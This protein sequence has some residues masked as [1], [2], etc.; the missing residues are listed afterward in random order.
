MNGLPTWGHMR[1][2]VR[3]AARRAVPEAVL[4]RARDLR[5][6]HRR[7]GVTPSETATALA[8]RLVLTDDGFTQDPDPYLE[9][10]RDAAAVHHLRRQECWLVVGYDAARSALM[11][12]QDFSSHP[13][14]GVES[15]LLGAD[16]ERHRATRRVL[17]PWFSTDVMSSARVYAE[18]AAT[19]LLSPL[20]GGRQFDVVREL[21]APLPT[22]VAG[23]LLGFDDALLS[24]LNAEPGWSGNLPLDP[25]AGARPVIE[26]SV[27]AVPSY[28]KLVAENDFRHDEAVDLIML[29]LVAGTVTTRGVLGSL[30]LRLADRA[31]RHEIT[32]RPEL[33]PGF[34]EEVLRLEPPVAVITRKTSRDVI[35]AGVEIPADSH[36]LV[37]TRA[38][39]RDPACFPDPGRLVLERPNK[40]DHL[41]FAAGPHHCLGARLARMELAVGVTVLLRLM[42]DFELVQPQHTLRY[43]G[44]DIR[45]VEQL[46]IRSARAH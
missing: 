18:E 4:G 9:R 7:P 23:W 29:L 36:V 15:T 30:V 32:S 10:L 34:I 40:R 3:A 31:V 46:V 39:N 6:P 37:A 35:L 16:G 26:S 20:A 17:A 44:G 24:Q 33:V 22:L 38:A 27:T 42:P 8:R 19:H 43:S 2:R 11:S 12:P 21:S 45:E 1:S 5:R 28:A 41:A 13:L 14:A 25:F